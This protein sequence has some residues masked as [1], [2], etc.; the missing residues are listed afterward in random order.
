ML[1]DWRQCLYVSGT[2]AADG[3][4]VSLM[5]RGI[6]VDERWPRLCSK[7]PALAQLRE[8]WPLSLLKQVSLSD[9]L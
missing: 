1:L 9:S 2:Q 5:L 4:P 7:L 6:H 8:T 3:L